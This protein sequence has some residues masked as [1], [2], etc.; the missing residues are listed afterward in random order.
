VG[1]QLHASAVSLPETQPSV[2]I[3]YKPG[4]PQRWSERSALFAIERRFI[5]LSLS[6]PAGHICPTYKESF[7]VRWDNGIALSLHAAMYLEVY[8]F[9]WTSQNAFSRETAVLYK[10]C[11]VQCCV[12]EKRYFKVDGSKEKKWDAVI[13]ADLKRLFVSGTYMSRW[14][15]KGWLSC[16][17]YNS[18]A[19]FS[20]SSTD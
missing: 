14:S 17:L 11:C 8:L 7:Q 16:P 9:R 4:W 13:P 2:R 20:K 6:W 15:R 5:G 1:G 10:W 19:T 18:M 3:E 12:A